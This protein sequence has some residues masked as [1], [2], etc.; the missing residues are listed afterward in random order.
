MSTTCVAV[1]V[2]ANA[3]AAGDPPSGPSKQMLRVSVVGSDAF[4]GST[5]AAGAPAGEEFNLWNAEARFM[6]LAWPQWIRLEAQNA[7]QQPESVREV[8]ARFELSAGVT[9][10]AFEPC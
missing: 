5:Q 10:F 4:A 8:R 2:H 1:L 7:N 3:S 6:P 9:V